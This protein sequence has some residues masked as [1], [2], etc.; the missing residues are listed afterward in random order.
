MEQTP[1]DIIEQARQCLLVE[2]LSGARRLLKEVLPAISS[3]GELLAQAGLLLLRA[4]S[5]GAALS[6]VKRSVKVEPA[7]AKGSNAYADV[8]WSLGRRGEAVHV[9][10]EGLQCPEQNEAKFLRAVRALSSCGLGERAGHACLKG[11][12]VYPDSIPLY[13]VGLQLAGDW[14]ML[15]FGETLLEQAE[16]AGSGVKRVAASYALRV[17]SFERFRGLEKHLPE[18]LG[19]QLACTLAL[20]EGDLSEGKAL[21]AHPDLPEEERSAYLAICHFLESEW[22]EGLELLKRIPTTPERA[23]WRSEALR[24]QGRFEESLSWAEQSKD[25]HGIRSLSGEINFFLSSFEADDLD[26]QVRVPK[27]TYEPVLEA[28]RPMIPD[29]DGQWNGK[30]R[31]LREIFRAALEAFRG[32]RTSGPTFLREGD[33]H[34]TRITGSHLL[35]GVRLPLILRRLF[36]DSWDELD[37]RLQMFD[38]YMPAS[39]ARVELA[40]RHGRSAEAGSCLESYTGSQE[41][42][43]AAGLFLLTGQADGALKVLAEDQGPRAALFRA[44]SLWMLD[45]NQEAGDELRRAGEG[46]MGHTLRCRLLRAALT[47]NTPE[48]L[49]ELRLVFPVTASFIPGEVISAE[50]RAIIEQGLETLGGFFAPGLESIRGDGGRLFGVNELN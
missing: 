36:L 1:R 7:T 6:C 45:R 20:W 16:Q 46:G 11:I 10:E 9:M 49:E 12:Q 21:A 24:N 43:L 37:G 30:V 34:L 18:T 8:L 23:T 39:L 38:D 14:H 22:K 50:T 19:P 32:N 4:G 15:S 28:L 3:N 48:A 27:G 47:E 42:L 35:P 17:G 26:G 25:S 31:F 2:D 33:T 41:P 13:K 40:L 5:Y 29:W 44:Q